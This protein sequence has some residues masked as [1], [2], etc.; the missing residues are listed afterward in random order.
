[1]TK[2]SSVY[3]DIKTFYGLC[4]EIPDLT[5]AKLLI[6]PELAH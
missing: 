3:Q 4:L 6:T 5:N 2:T 1:M